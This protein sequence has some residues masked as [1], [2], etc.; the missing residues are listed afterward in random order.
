MARS[1]IDKSIPWFR[2]GET[3]H[4]SRYPCLLHMGI[5]LH[6]KPWSNMQ[7]DISS[8]YLTEDCKTD[9]RV[10]VASPWFYSHFAIASCNCADWMKWNFI[11]GWVDNKISPVKIISS[12]FLP[13][14]DDHIFNPHYSRFLKTPNFEWHEQKALSLYSAGIFLNVINDITDSKRVHSSSEECDGQQRNY[15]FVIKPVNY[16]G[17]FIKPNPLLFCDCSFKNESLITN[18]IF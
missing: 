18:S 3:W 6:G 14:E 17:W 11:A 15:Y 8:Y 12:G 1:L 5:D 7:D 4:R 9:S 13:P 2:Y 10:I 16:R